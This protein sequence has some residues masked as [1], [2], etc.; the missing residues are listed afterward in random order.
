MLFHQ[1]WG[2]ILKMIFSKVAGLS[3]IPVFFILA[4]CGGALEG[5]PV[6]SGQPAPKK[7]SSKPG[8]AIVNRPDGEEVAMSNQKTDGV[9]FLINQDMG[10]DRSTSRV[11]ERLDFPESHS[12]FE[13]RRSG[14]RPRRGT[15]LPVVQNERVQK[16]IKAFT[17][18]L[19]SNYGR[20]LGRAGKHGPLIESILKEYKLPMDLIYL[21]MIESGLNLN[22]YSHA[23]AAGPWQFIRSTGQMYGLKAGGYIDERRDIEKATRAAAAH[24][25]DL[26]QQYGDWNLAFAAYNA[27]PG[28]V[29]KAM[30]RSGERDYWK[31]TSGKKRFFRPETI[32][33]VPKI[34]AA[35]I[36]AKNYKKFGF[37]PDL[38]QSPDEV[39]KVTVNDSIDL[40]TVAECAG[41][42]FEDVKNLNPQYLMHVTPPNMQ[43]EIRLPEGTA[44]RFEKNFA[45]IPPSQRVKLVYHKVGKKETLA[46]VA[47]KYGTSVSNLAVANNLS[48]K[49]QLKPGSKLMIPRKSSA[50]S[51]LASKSSQSFQSSAASSERSVVEPITTEAAPRATQKRI[52]STKSHKVKKGE[53]LA[54]IA[55]KYGTTIT[56]LKKMNRLN[57]GVLQYGQTLKV[58]ETVKIISVPAPVLAASLSPAVSPLSVASAP[59]DSGSGSVGSSAL[60]FQGQGDNDDIDFQPP[61]EGATASPDS[62]AVLDVGD[63]SGIAGAQDQGSDSFLVQDIGQDV[64]PVA[65]FSQKPRPF[66]DKKIYVVQPGD[67]LWK[68]AT[69][70]GLT[71]SDLMD[72][73]PNIRNGHLEA[74]QKLVLPA[75]GHVLASSKRIDKKID[76]RVGK[77]VVHS[78]RAGETLWDVSKKYRVTV[79][80][81]KTWNRLKNNHV[82]PKQKLIVYPAS[83]NPVAMR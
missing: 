35:A 53:T 54:G 71:V 55:K 72:A 27:G 43:C 47:K 80:Q 2:C 70:A 57:K 36:I 59:T 22:A 30:A 19:R 42:A 83:S 48:I 44:N 33:Y 76:A 29:N 25:R 46:T 10:S 8:F 40:A 7:S 45:K 65:D 24:L 68:V 51:L 31:M 60:Q 62:L 9:A 38:F 74:H 79:A 82:Y 63:G 16:W 34:Y 15:D 73:N 78:V 58:G 6:S 4:S 28:S 41:V 49:S 64:L 37:S 50:S 13:S 23:N 26:Y 39:E 3:V 11:V 77:K 5:S 12:A 61:S 81:I 20:W 32:D 14:W 66:V 1:D 18:P 69:N 75:S 17:G 52:V 56:A 67:T 21:A